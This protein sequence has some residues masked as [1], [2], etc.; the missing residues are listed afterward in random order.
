MARLLLL[1]ALSILFVVPAAAQVINGETPLDETAVKETP[2][3]AVPHPA[4]AESPAAASSE[5]PARAGEPTSADI[6]HE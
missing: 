4:A 1:A 6:R 2:V 3:P 5:P